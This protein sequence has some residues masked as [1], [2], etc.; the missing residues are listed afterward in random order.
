MLATRAREVYSTHPRS[1]TR[2]RQVIPAHRVPCPPVRMTEQRA[3]LYVCTNANTRRIV[4][5]CFPTAQ[6]VFSSLGVAF[7]APSTYVCRDTRAP[8]IGNLV[9]CTR[10][11]YSYPGF[12]DRNRSRLSS[13]TLRLYF[14]QGCMKYYTS[15]GDFPPQTQLVSLTAPAPAA[16]PSCRFA[17][18]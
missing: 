16:R 18:E 4:F 11:T 15:C 9:Y 8:T 10:V 17:A 5:F 12:H 1:S 7:P 13:Y 6:V 14:A 3:L 2:A